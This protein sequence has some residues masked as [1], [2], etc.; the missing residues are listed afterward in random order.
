M[1]ARLLLAGLLAV[2]LSG[3]GSPAPAAPDY[4]GPGWHT[5]A[6]PEGWSL[7]LEY[8]ASSGQELPWAWA[9][10]GGQDVLF[11][12]LHVE[13]SATKPL[14]YQRGNESDGSRLTPQSGRY[15]YIW[16]NDAFGN[17]N[18]TLHYKVPDGYIEHVWPPGQGTGCT[19]LLRAAAC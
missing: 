17:G 13:G 11:Q 12:V 18:V 4:T 15:D 2:A 7:D 1:D 8:V 10:E 9:I 5:T 16:D 3:C 6:V 14:V 19:F